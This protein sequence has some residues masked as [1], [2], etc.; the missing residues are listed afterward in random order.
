MGSMP[1]IEE[2]AAMFNQF[3]EGMI[4]HEASG[5]VVETGPEAKNWKAGDRYYSNDIEGSFAEYVVVKEEETQ[6]KLHHLP[7]ELTFEQGA[8]IEPTWVAVNAVAKSDIEP[9]ET[10]AILG[11]G[12]IG[13]L[14]L[15]VCRT[16]GARV[17]VSEINPMRREKA[18]VLGADQ[19]FS[20]V[21]VNVIERVKQ[22]TGE[23][24]DIV[25]ETV[26]IQQTLDQMLSILKNHGRG[27]AISWWENPVALDFNRIVARSLRINGVKSTPPA[28]RQWIRENCWP[29]TLM[30]EGKLDIDPIVTSTYPLD[31]IDDAFRATL[32]G[33]ELKVLIHP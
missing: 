15:Q 20:P 26:G 18:K 27:V 14:A 30:L 9:G 29:E 28:K 10:V 23:G 13:L 11:G 3:Y 5:T 8:V 2:M 1:V 22:L 24:V 16:L 31:R 12:A 32:E 7:D 17:F 21:E 25:I 6:G 4:G 33:K 19:V